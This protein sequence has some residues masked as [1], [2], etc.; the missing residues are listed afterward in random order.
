MKPAEGHGAGCVKAQPGGT[1]P[2]E[3]Q[4][5]VPSSCKDEAHFLR[6]TCLAGG[7]G[8][9]GLGHASRRSV[10]GCWEDTSSP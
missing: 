4:G 10:R 1:Q 3:I 6:R 8:E 5:C 7:F 9:L 2:R